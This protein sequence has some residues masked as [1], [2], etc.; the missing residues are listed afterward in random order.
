MRGGAVLSQISDS[1]VT[2]K[3]YKNSR[4]LTDSRKKPP[5]K[6]NSNLNMMNRPS[7]L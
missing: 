5:G 1:P 3:K 2:D 6:I 4:T 7:K